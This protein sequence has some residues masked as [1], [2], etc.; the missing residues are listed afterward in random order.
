MAWHIFLTVRQLRSELDDAIA[1]ECPF[2]GELMINEITL[3]FIKPEESLHSASWDLRPQ[4]NLANQRTI[5]LPVWFMSHFLFMWSLLQLA[6]ECECDFECFIIDVIL[7]LNMLLE[8]H[9]ISLLT[10][11]SLYLDVFLDYYIALKDPF[12]FHGFASVTRFFL[13]FKIFLCR[14]FLRQSLLGPALQVISFLERLLL[15]GKFS[16]CNSNCKIIWEQS[17]PDKGVQKCG[18]KQN[19]DHCWGD[20]GES[21]CQ[22]SA[23]VTRY[24]LC[25]FYSCYWCCCHRK[26]IWPPRHWEPAQPL[27]HLVAFNTSSILKLYKLEMDLLKPGE[28][29][30]P[31]YKGNV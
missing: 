4:T 2:C 27:S 16:F 31:H 1:S 17:S 10:Y 12:V 11:S 30:D 3:P 22:S 29:I 23:R 19:A 28:E 14:Y 13:G 25:I 20:E 7:L 24:C 26:S 15:L 21:E 5:S 9:T 8:I 6:L 18:D